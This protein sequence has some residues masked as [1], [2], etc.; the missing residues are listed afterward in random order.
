VGVGIV[1]DSRL[2][3]LRVWV[4]SSLGYGAI[5]R[6]IKGFCERLSAGRFWGRVRS[7]SRSG[8]RS[9][10]QGCDRGLTIALQGTEGTR[11]C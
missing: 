2:R 5:A 11:L 8:G 6:K 7:G 1:L 4:F 3:Q 9:G 10:F